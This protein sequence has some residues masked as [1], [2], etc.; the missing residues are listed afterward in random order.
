MEEARR[1]GRE[2]GQQHDDWSTTPLI[3]TETESGETKKADDKSSYEPPQTPS[4]PLLD[5]STISPSFTTQRQTDLTPQE[6]FMSMLDE[7]SVA[8]DPSYMISG[9][10]LKI[11]KISFY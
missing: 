5:P 2:I 3:P 1:I 9:K 8:R 7:F 10:F 4:A 6:Q 11:C